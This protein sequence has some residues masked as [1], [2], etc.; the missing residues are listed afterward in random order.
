MVEVEWGKIPTPYDVFILG[1]LFVRLLEGLDHNYQWADIRHWLDM[2][3]KMKDTNNLKTFG[4][5]ADIYRKDLG[6][7]YWDDKHYIETSDRE[8]LKGWVRWS[9]GRLKELSKQW[10]LS[11]PQAHLDIDKLIGGVGLFLKNEELNVLEPI[12]QQGLDESASCLLHNNFT[13][14]EFIALRTAESLLRRWYQKKTGNKLERQMWG[15]ILD[16]LNELYPKKAERPKE[17]SL[18][19]Y[20]RGRRNE[21][22]HP[23][24]ISNPEEA[25]ATFLNVIA[26]CKAVKSE[27][28]R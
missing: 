6:K 19:D 10:V 1:Q 14:A 28:L 22:A 4:L 18:L 3:S 16:E 20:L 26:V 8:V 5:Q 9:E 17:L 11:F 13:S 27:L 21:I 25:T 2:L 7:R 23:E 24:A 15:E 12:E